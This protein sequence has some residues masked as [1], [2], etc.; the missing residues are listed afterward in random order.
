MTRIE[1]EDLPVIEELSRAEM[2]DVVGGGKDGGNDDGNGGRGNNSWD[3][4][5]GTF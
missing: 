4:H 3:G 2:I 5:Q 1:I